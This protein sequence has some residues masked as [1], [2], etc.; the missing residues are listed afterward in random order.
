MSPVSGP[1]GLPLL[2]E[3]SLPLSKCYFLIAN[4]VVSINPSTF[5]MLSLVWRSVLK[6]SFIPSRSC[7][8]F[9]LESLF[10]GQASSRCLVVSLFLYQQALE[11]ERLIWCK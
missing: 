6:E 2:G 5:S 7:F 10:S 9:F 1:P 8:S 4:R 11:S 3:F